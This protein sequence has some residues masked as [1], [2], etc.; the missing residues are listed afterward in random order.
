MTHASGVV[1]WIGFPRSQVEF[2]KG[3][4]LVHDYVS[5]PGTHR[6]FC[7]RCGTRLTFESGHGRWAGEVHLPLALF[8]GPVDR[9]P[10]GNSFP[11]ERP[12]WAPFHAFPD[13]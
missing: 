3:A 5:S 4:E 8:V 7:S 11:G 13:E 9:P 1:T 10:G 12:P 2:V 6:R